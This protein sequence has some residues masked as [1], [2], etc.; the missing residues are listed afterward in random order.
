[1]TEREVMDI[2]QAA[3]YLGICPDTLYR[4]A[5]ERQVPAFKMGNRWRF[6][7]SR[8][9]E[10]INEQIDQGGKRAAQEGNSMREPK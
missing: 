4:Y 6:K 9:D 1:M 7:R 8:L 10:W 5:L 3:E 2:H